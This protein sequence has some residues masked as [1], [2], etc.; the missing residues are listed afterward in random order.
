MI[1]KFIPETSEERKMLGDEPNHKGVTDIFVF[2]KEKDPDGDAVDFHFWKGS[3]QFL[4]G[5]LGYFTNNI[6]DEQRR[7]M[8]SKKVSKKDVDINNSEASQF[9]NADGS[10]ANIIPFPKANEI[11]DA[12]VAE[13]VEQSEGLQI[14]PEVKVDEKTEETKEVANEDVNNQV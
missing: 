12:E 4:L 5:N 7:K 14:V 1:V 6:A 3:Y 9:A 8:G 11:K 13:V 2:G 10:R